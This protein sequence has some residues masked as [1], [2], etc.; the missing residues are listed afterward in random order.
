MVLGVNATPW[1]LFPQE[2]SGTL[3][4]GSWVHLRAGVDYFGKSRPQPGFNPRT[5]QPVASLYTDYTIPAQGVGVPNYLY[6][7][8]GLNKLYGKWWYDEW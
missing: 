5:V 2:W 7:Q 6:D 1:P 8:L 3:C 4:I